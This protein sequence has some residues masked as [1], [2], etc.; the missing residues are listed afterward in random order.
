VERRVIQWKM[1]PGALFL[2][3][4]GVVAFAEGVT[5]PITRSEA[6]DESILREEVLSDRLE[7]SQA[8]HGRQLR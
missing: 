7:E 5:F 4:W 8:Q 3:L 6:T 2:L 1:N